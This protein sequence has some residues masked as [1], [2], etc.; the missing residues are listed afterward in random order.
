LK[1]KRP[2]TQMKKDFLL[3]TLISLIFLSLIISVNLNINSNNN[4]LDTTET[5]MNIF[6]TKFV[7]DVWNKSLDASIDLPGI[8]I[9]CEEE[10]LHGSY[11]TGFLTTENFT[12]LCNIKIRGHS[13]ATLAK[14]G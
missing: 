10:I 12:L 2:V 14:K 11:I 5:P 8:Y 1:E 9:L 6:N 4:G 3:F 7:P 13:V